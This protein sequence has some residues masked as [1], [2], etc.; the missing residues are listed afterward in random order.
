MTKHEIERQL[1]QTMLNKLPEGFA[2]KG[3]LLFHSPIEWFIRG[4][5]FHWSEYD[6]NI[7]RVIAFVSPLYVPEAGYYY[8]LQQS[9]GFLCYHQEIWWREFDDPQII[10]CITSKGEQ[11][12]GEISTPYDYAVKAKVIASKQEILPDSVLLSREI[13]Y[14]YLLAGRHEEAVAVLQDICLR[15]QKRLEEGK[16]SDWDKKFYEEILV[17][18][19]IVG[20]E[21]VAK[22]LLA[23]YRNEQLSILK[24]EKFAIQL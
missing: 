22:E 15:L 2:A 13:A 8:S 7:F 14:S 3:Q 4:Y 20:D 23:N 11:W 5:G 10:D 24:M 16:L 1:K 19:N 6:K 17:M 12:V 18:E 21:K 9:I